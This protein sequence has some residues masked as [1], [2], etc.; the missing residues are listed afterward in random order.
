MLVTG[1]VLYPHR[2]DLNHKCFWRCAPC[3]SHVGTHKGTT[4]PLGTLANPI[5]RAARIQAHNAFDRIWKSGK[6]K[7]KEAYLWLA[8]RLNKPSGECHISW[9]NEDEC[10][11]VVAAVRD[12][13]P[14]Q[15]PD[16]EDDSLMFYRGDWNDFTGD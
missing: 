11:A 3:G 16:D 15:R 13:K 8:E 14:N 7:R 1:D 9:M 4:N 12:Y 5:L 2:S 10:L 6:M